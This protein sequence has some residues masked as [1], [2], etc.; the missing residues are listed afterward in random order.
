MPAERVLYRE[1]AEAQG[2][3]ICPRRGITHG[4]GGRGPSGHAWGELA[5]AAQLGAYVGRLPWRLANYD[6]DM[7]EVAFNPAGDAGV[8]GLT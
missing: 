5:F 3:T 8:R 2:L 7:A 1:Q 4:S 6:G